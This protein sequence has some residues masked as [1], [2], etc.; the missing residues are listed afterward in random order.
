M[1]EF[2]EDKTFLNIMNNLLYGKKKIL[3]IMKDI[4]EKTPELSIDVFICILHKRINP[5][6]SYSGM[7]AELYRFSVNLW[8][9]RVFDNY[10]CDF[11]L[12]ISHKNLCF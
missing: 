9:Q 11:D 3:E 6:I 4:K 2:F 1:Q 10:K 7:G 12:L 5:T 8:N